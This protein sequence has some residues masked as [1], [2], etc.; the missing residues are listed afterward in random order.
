MAR[1]FFA[2]PVENEAKDAIEQWCSPLQRAYA[3]SWVAPENY[4]V[5]LAFVGDTKEESIQNLIDYVTPELDLGVFPFQWTVNHLS[6]FR[7]G[8]LYLTGH[9]TPPEMTKLARSLAF[10]IPAEHKHP[11]FIP[12]ITLARNTQHVQSDEFE[13]RLNFEEII[14]FESNLSNSGSVYSPVFR[15]RN[16]KNR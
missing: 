1:L 6:V 9:N 14:L 7:S 10:F 3:G 15:W 16:E 8:V 5:T 11:N 2:L 4:H 13:L 12:H